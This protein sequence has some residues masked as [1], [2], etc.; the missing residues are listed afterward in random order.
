MP[1]TNGDPAARHIKNR[2]INLQTSSEKSFALAQKWLKECLESHKDCR[3]GPWDPNFRPT[4]VIEILETSPSWR[5]RL[6]RPAA[7]VNY[8]ALSYCWGGPQTMLTAKTEK[9]WETSLPWAELSQ[10]IKDSVYVSAKLGFKY[11]WVDALCIVQDDMTDKMAEI[12]KMVHVYSAATLTVASSSAAAATEG[13]LQDRKFTDFPSQVFELPVRCPDGQLGSATLFRPPPS[14]PLTS[15]PLNARGWALQERLLS[16]RILDFKKLQLRWTCETL[17][18]NHVQSYSDGWNNHVE[19]TVFIVDSSEDPHSIWRRMV[20]AYT[21]R[22]LT[23][24]TDRILAISGI[25][26][27][28]SRG[29]E[30]EYW[31]G[32]WE[33]NLPLCLMWKSTPVDSEYSSGSKSATLVPRPPTY[34]GP[35]W[36]WVSV[37]TRTHYRGFTTNDVDIHIEVLGCDIELVDERA[38]YGAVKG[39]QLRIRGRTRVGMLHYTPAI[40]RQN[41]SWWKLD[42]GLANGNAYATG[43]ALEP[44]FASPTLSPIRVHLLEVMRRVDMLNDRAGDAISE[45]LILRHLTS[46]QYSRLGT[47]GFYTDAMPALKISQNTWFDGCDEEIL[48]LI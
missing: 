5:I 26:E 8:V 39:A 21:L 27:V 36:S 41:K 44:E 37:N 25:A 28:L 20:Y 23:V 34:Q 32:L 3:P 30:G 33:S 1:C 18:L 6:F 38:M 17:P 22:N 15:E 29:I 43:D 45:G 11:L 31:A 42:A 24:A 13:F 2:L 12:A 9:A 14:T 40:V 16:S 47:F 48:C 19:D 35:S 4:R 46:E 7:Q 10:T